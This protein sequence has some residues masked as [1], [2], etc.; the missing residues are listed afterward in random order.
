MQKT[1]AA[2]FATKRC[3]LSPISSKLLFIQFQILNW[4]YCFYFVK[5]I[6]SDLEMTACLVEILCLS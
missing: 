5:H 4:V 1:H 2:F 6:D 3:H